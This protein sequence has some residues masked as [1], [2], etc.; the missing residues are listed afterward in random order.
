MKITYKGDYALKAVLELALS[1]NESLITS[2]DLA[3]R[4]DAPIKFMEQVLSGLK[5]GGFIKSKRGSIGGY[6]LSKAPREITVGDVVRNIEGPIEPIEC[7]NKGY[8]DCIDINKCVF[9]K[10]W[11]DVYEATSNIIDHVTFAD[12]VSQVNA[13]K[14]ALT[15]SI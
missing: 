14:Q 13:G 2:H 12:L 10:V 4:I 9:K 7:I 11:R 8:V 1:Y 15:Y 3:K 5:K 6:M